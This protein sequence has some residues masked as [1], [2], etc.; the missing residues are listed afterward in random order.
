[1]QTGF[2]HQH[3]GSEILLKEEFSNLAGTSINLTS[4]IMNFTSRKFLFFMALITLSSCFADNSN[5]S[6]LETFSLNGAWQVARTGDGKWLPATVPGCIHTDLLAAGKIPDPFFRD[7]EQKIQWIG[8]TNWTY[9]RTFE[10]SAADLAHDRVLL[11]C[12]GLDTFATIRVNGHELARTDNM[13]RTYEF[14]AKPVLK[15]GTNTI[16]ILFES[17][18]PYMQKRNVERE[19]YEWSGSHEP[20]GRAWVRKE[21]CNFGWDWGPVLITCG[22]WKNIEL[23][24]FDEA[25]LS[26]V[27]I[28]QDLSDKKAAKLMVQIT[29]ETTR[30][31][32]L[33]G[34]VTLTQNHQLVAKSTVSLANGKAA[35]DLTIT[36]PKLWWPNGMGKQPLYEVRV[37]LLS[38]NRTVLDS[39]TKRIGLRTV[40][41]LPADETH[42]IRFAVNGVP[43]FAKGAN[44]IP[45]DPFPNRVMPETLRRYMADAVTV[46]MNTLRFWGGGYYEEDALYDACDELGLLVWSDCK[47]ACSS[48]PAFDAEFMENVRQ[49]IRDNIQRLRHHPS[50]AVWCGNNEI[51][52]MTKP[53]WSTNSMG[54]ADYDQMFSGLIADEVKSLAPQSLYV[55]GSPEVGDLHYWQVWHG[56]K[57]FDAYRSLNGFMSEFGFQSFPEPRSVNSYTIAEDRT[58]LHT[59][60]MDWHQRSSGDGN[61]KISDMLERYFQ[62]A[63][64][65]DS[66]LW[67]SQILQ[68]YGIKTGAE[69]WRQNMPKSMG[70]IYWQFNDC[71]PVTSWSSVDYYGRWKALHYLARH[72]YAPVLVSGLENTT[73]QSVAIYATSDL[74]KSASG[75][76]TWEVTDAQGTTLTKGKESLELAAQTSRMVKSLELRELAGKYGANN[77]LIWLKLE[78]KGQPVS[79]NLVMLVYPKELPL[80]G[81]NVD[82]TI[83]KSGHS[84]RVTLT[85]D[86]PALW[87]WLSLKNEDAT[88]SDNFVHLHPGTSSQIRVTPSREM[89]AKEFA[90]AL[91]VRSLIDTYDINR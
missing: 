66:A 17:V 9:R 55:P 12:E 31:S 19:L 61:K 15:A 56:G 6:N 24:L 8:E 68:G 25:R 7:N 16:E 22:I 30:P 79:E 53:E 76:L 32:A 13:F 40:E 89:T 91:Q 27:A 64:D 57:S 83:K 49:E 81:V 14:D 4:Y 90:Q 37:E 62:P 28:L 5:A 1:L 63:K 26:D 50:I 51:S 44:W 77:L 34:L 38:T 3:P 23:V 82:T 11:R 46:N 41:L 54:K 80:S 21:P 45:A 88:Y 52:L 10:I 2:L 33:Q 73:N 71:W 29:A 85:A 35:A 87:T 42:S 58:S 86:K 39:S 84:F 59:P 18:L 43:F 20:K 70:C 72:F 48:Y 47:F 60:I 78:V 69:F 36:D 75:K 67:L 74:L 65:F